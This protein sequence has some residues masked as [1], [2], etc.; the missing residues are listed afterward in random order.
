MNS[1][2]AVVLL[3]AVNAAATPPA[4][5]AGCLAFDAQ[6]PTLV[7]GVTMYPQAIP[8]VINLAV[9]S[10]EAAKAQPVGGVTYVIVMSASCHRIGPRAMQAGNFGPLFYDPRAHACGPIIQKPT[11]GQWTAY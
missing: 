9:C 3:A 5:P 11:K 1:L 4:W 10:D 2:I 8:Q 7:D 6:K